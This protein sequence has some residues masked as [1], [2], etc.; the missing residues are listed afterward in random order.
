VRCRA[1]ASA[2]KNEISDGTT[3][4]KT[5]GVYIG[6]CINLKS[7]SIKISDDIIVYHNSTNLSNLKKFSYH[8]DIMYSWLYSNLLVHAQLEHLFIT[9]SGSKVYCGIE[10]LRLINTQNLQQLV[11]R[12][13]NM[14]AVIWNLYDI[15]KLKLDALVT[16]K[17]KTLFYG[18][19]DIPNNDLHLVM[20]T[21]PNLRLLEIECS[22]IGS[23]LAE[24]IRNLKS[25][26]AL[27]LTMYC[28]L[29]S[30]EFFDVNGDLSKSLEQ[31]FVNYEININELI[32]LVRTL[33]N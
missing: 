29:D 33:K 26:Q 16:L 20:R 21:M 30:V 8:G 6:R 15:M 11:L 17:I 10:L 24:W 4:C 23:N 18:T 32:R 1:E 28:S 19:Y 9:A 5:I 14:N 22:S 2:K 12:D 3:T 27:H 7:L 13:Y 31:Y 25:L